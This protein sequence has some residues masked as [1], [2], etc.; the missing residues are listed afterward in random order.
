MT[1]RFI[2][3]LTTVLGL[4]V[5]LALAGQPVPAQTY[6]TKPIRL[7]VPYPAG[8]GT[9]FFA[10]A[11]GAKLSENLGQ[12]I[13]VE[14]RPGAATIIGAEAVARAAPDGY[15]LLLG[16]TATFAVN[17]SLYKKLP[18]DPVKDFQ[19]ISL[20]G[21]FALLLVVHPS[22]QAGSVKE[23][24]ALAKS[25]PGQL[26]YASPG[27]GSPHHLAM[28]L[29]KQRTSVD[30]VHVPYKGS[31][32]AVQDLLGGRIP[33]MFLDLAT[34]A[35]HIKAGKI[36][37]LAVASPKRITVMPDLATVADSGVP[38]YEAWA[39]QG[40]VAPAKTPPEIVAKLGAEYAKA[41]ADTGVKE[42]VIEAGIDPLQ[43]SPQALAEYIKSEQAKWAKVVKDGGISVE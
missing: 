2:T 29:F 37:A 13:V 15:T 10:R 4:G 30:I 11:V 40:L 7:I 16:D 23:L 5:G 17:P 39:W 32:P 43:S 26:S 1:L 3:R 19:P 28:E 21:R 42:K 31:A 38:G 41:I 8:G 25:K 18:Y 14:N 33:V 35:P 20:T 36:K 9:D 12:Q 24:I 34:G 6:P 22:V 27:P